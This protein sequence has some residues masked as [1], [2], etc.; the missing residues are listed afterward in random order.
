V[1][2][3]TVLSETS[4]AT[5]TAEPT[6]GKPK[7]PPARRL[8]RL[9]IWGAVG[10]AVLAA[11][12]GSLVYTE[13]SG[14]C[15]T[16][17]EMS[18]YY[19][20]WASGGHA[21]RAECV[22]CHVD[23]GVIAHLAH[24]PVALKELWNHFF[25]T[26]RFPSF[27]AELPNA[28]CVRCHETVLDTQGSLL[29]F[30]HVKHQ[31]R[32]QCKDCHAETGHLVTTAT[33]DAAGILDSSAT[34]PTIPGMTPSA[35]AGHAAVLCQSC[36]DQAKMKCSECHLPKHTAR[37]E[38]SGCHVPGEGFAF[39]HVAD[40]DCAKCHDAPAGHFGKD[41]ASCHDSTV[42]FAKT[43]FTHVSGSKCTTCHKA[44]GS[45]FGTSCATCHSPSVPFKDTKFT[46]VAG[47]NCASCHRA[48]GGH[49]HAA[50]SSCHKIGVAFKNATFTHSASSNCASCHRPPS[51]HYRTSCSTCHRPSVPFARATFRHPGGLGEHTSRSFA[52][53]KCHPSGYRT[54]YCSCHG[55]HP[56]SGD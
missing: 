13:T 10:V 30:S 51:G 12:V 28:R 24:K 44:P 33:L 32:A 46:H 52:C 42:P 11:L 39:H 31:S 16:C 23:P 43:V 20:A 40:T 38:C 34:T 35:T 3:E 2:E 27:T 25:R 18:P 22:D 1:S 7:Q 50:C 26:N 48:P 4:T 15:P 56:P 45:H 54:S 17:H 29:L 14:F 5:T 8:R 36:H 37:G 9:I 6:A 21:G 47:S 53:A 55:G 19:D 41:C 49:F